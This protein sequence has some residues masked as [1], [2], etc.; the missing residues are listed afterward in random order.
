M[1][2]MG[3]SQYKQHLGNVHGLRERGNGA[4]ISG[5]LGLQ[6]QF[7]VLQHEVLSKLCTAWLGILRL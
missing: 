7:P 6:R 3:F 2:L 4:A 1:N 5:F